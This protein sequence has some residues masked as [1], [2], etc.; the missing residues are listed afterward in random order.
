[1]EANAAA[2]IR[3]TP[4]ECEPAVHT[5]ARAFEGYPLMAHL[6]P[7]NASRARLLPRCLRCVVRYGLLFGEV[8]ATSPRFEAVAVWLPPQSVEASLGGMARAGVFWLPLTLGPRFFRRFWAFFER[9][10]EMRK[11]HAPF[12][13]WYLQMI[14]TDPAHEKKGHASALL[15]AMLNR[16]DAERAACC[17]DTETCENAVYYRR[18]GFS[19]AEATKVP[20]SSLDC[21]FMVRPARE[22]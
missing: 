10:A 4:V 6:L 15:T 8:Y 11:R 3:L 7:D 2:P 20:G 9:V 18:F 12:A 5:L 22:A 1:M 17:L 16:L 14:G 13:H 21:W 19:A